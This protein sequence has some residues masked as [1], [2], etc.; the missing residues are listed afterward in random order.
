M[1][2]ERDHSVGYIDNIYLHS[3]SFEECQQNIDETVQLFGFVVHKEKSVLKP[4]QK[5]EF[6]SFELDL[7]DMEVRLMEKKRDKIKNFVKIWWQKRNCQL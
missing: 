3:D 6:L 5:V 2:R 7:V 4:V 1:L